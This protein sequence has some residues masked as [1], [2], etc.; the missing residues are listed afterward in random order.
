MSKQQ[1]LISV[2]IDTSPFYALLIIL[3]N[4]LNKLLF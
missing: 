2:E 1:P 4:T 3:E